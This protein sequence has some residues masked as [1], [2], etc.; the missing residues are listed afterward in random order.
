MQ[1]RWNQFY[2]HQRPCLKIQRKR[3]T[4]T[5][6]F[7]LL[8]T[9]T[10]IHTPDYMHEHTYIDHTKPSQKQQDGKQLRRHQVL[11]SGLHVYTHICVHTPH[12]KSVLQM[13]HQIHKPEERF[14][15]I[16]VFLTWQA[17]QFIGKCYTNDKNQKSRTLQGLDSIPYHS[18]EE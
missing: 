10:C 18:M 14:T 15:R 6:N 12:T 16:R 17:G 4:P 1:H 7:R 8:Q 11:L 9:H 5:I 2:I 3:K 13:G